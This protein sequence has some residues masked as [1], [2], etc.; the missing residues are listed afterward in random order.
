[1]EEMEAEFKR[2]INKITMDNS[3][4]YPVQ[5][6]DIS[7]INNSGYNESNYQVDKISYSKEQ[8]DTSSRSGNDSVKQVDPSSYPRVDTHINDGI[9]K[10]LIIPITYEPVVIGQ[11]LVTIVRETSLEDL[12]RESLKPL[13]TISSK[14]IVTGAACNS[15]QVVSIV[16]TPIRAIRMM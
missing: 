13:H 11:D 2:N 15:A 7:K 5:K 10:L 6:K 1:M 9:Q 12:S 4:Q 14:E 16:Q 8:V 3:F